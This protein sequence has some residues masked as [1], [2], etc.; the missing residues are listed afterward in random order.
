MKRRGFLGVTAAA[1]ALL[2]GGCKREESKK[3]YI[4]K[5]RKITV[6]LATSWPANFPIMGE[7]V[8]EFA[9]QVHNASGGEV[10]VKV[11]AKNL[12]VPAL[13]VFDACS[14]GQI[15]AFHSGPY[16]WKGKNPAFSLFGGFP[17]G[18]TSNEMNAWMLYGGGLEIWRKLYS[19]YNLYPLLGG[20]TDVQMGGWFRK[21]I[22]SLGDLKGLKMRIPGLGGEVMAKLGVNPILLPAGEI[23]T[24][25]DRGTIDATEW[26]GPALDIKMGFYKV[27]KFYYSGFHEPGSVLELTFN[28]KFWQTLP[29]DIQS[30]LQ[31]CANELNAKMVYNFQAKNAQA[32]QELRKLGVTLKNWP[33]EIVEAAKKALFQVIE[34]Q[35]SKSQDF[36]EVWSKI[37]PFWQQN[38]SWSALGLKNYLEMRDS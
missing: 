24:A 22:K 7:G 3:V 18:F 10:V 13:G 34:E 21:E 12:L 17:F 25:L 29:H 1:T 38:R 9:K 32:L 15:E 6:K 27:A 23:Y 19:K 8:N 11:F 36:K 4:S 26:V 30:L 16:Y 20:N 33:E 28:K 37:E 14:A 2:L 31:S 5:K 35:S